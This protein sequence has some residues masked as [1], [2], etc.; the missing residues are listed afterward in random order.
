MMAIQGLTEEGLLLSQ[1]SYAAPT[2]VHHQHAVCWRAVFAGAVAAAA[3]SILLAILGAG[4]GLA[5]V[6]PWSANGV[7]AGTFGVTAILWLSLTQIIASGLGGFLSGRLRSRAPGVDADEVYFRDTAHGF[8]TWSI[9]L[10][11][12]ATLFASTLGALVNG[13]VQAGAKLGGAVVASAG[14]LSAGAIANDTDSYYIDSLF[15]KSST[16]HAN[17]D[18]LSAAHFGTAGEVRRIFTKSLSDK[19]LA[20]NDLSYL[21]TVVA[22]RTGL[23]QAEAETRVKQ[24]YQAMESSKTAVKEAADKARKASAYITLW[25]FIALLIGAFTASLAATWGGR[26]RDSIK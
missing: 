10:L 13:S 25:A 12:S 8:L 14:A 23:S 1:P 7:D 15:R 19:S 11:V 17:N 24:T 16:A 9:A 18:P 21:G 4:F 2:Q 20:P 6:S 5:I 3:L 26:Y 22:E